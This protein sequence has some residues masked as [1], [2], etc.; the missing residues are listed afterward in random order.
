MTTSLET[1]YNK[2]RNLIA[3]NFAIL[4]IDKTRRG[5]KV[6]IKPI[7]KNYPWTHFEGTDLAD[8]LQRAIKQLE[9]PLKDYKDVDGCVWKA[10][11]PSCYRTQH[12]E[13]FLR[14]EEKET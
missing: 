10:T 14:E 4:L 13:Q 3:D 11:D 9:N 2:L 7:N 12:I 6:T 5:A 1:T 8:A